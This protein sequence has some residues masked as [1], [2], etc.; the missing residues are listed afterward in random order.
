MMEILELLDAERYIHVISIDKFMNRI[1]DSHM[2]EHIEYS[3]KNKSIS[4]MI[5]VRTDWEL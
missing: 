5:H 4:H 2:Y 3:N 1:S